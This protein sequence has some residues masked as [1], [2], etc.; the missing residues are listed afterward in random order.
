[1]PPQ[2]EQPAVAIEEIF[3][4]ATIADMQTK[5][6]ANLFM[7][8]ISNLL[9]FDFLLICAIHDVNFAKT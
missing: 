1:V 9:V 6:N 4:I 8:A 3:N 7:N 5:R 2:V